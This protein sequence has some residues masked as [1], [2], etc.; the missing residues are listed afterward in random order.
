[1]WAMVALV[2]AATVLV[3][4]PAMRAEFIWN[5]IDYV[6]A[7]ALQ[8]AAGLKR[9]WVEVGATE[10]YYPLLHTAFWVEHMLWGDTPLGYHLVNVLLHAGAACLFA[11]VL[12]R[13]AVPGAWLAALLF[14]LHPICVES[15]AWISEQK[16]TLSLVFY[17]GAA[18]AWLR[19]D[20]SRE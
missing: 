6:T 10:Q 20:A 1:A 19:F 15:V 14:A 16:N 18:L 11:A 5:D 7:P 12:R 17:L 8:S 2:F 9:I 13:L 4:L 3:Y